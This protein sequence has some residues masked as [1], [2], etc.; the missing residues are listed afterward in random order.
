MGQELA[1]TL[2]F[3]VQS[4]GIEFSQFGIEMKTYAYVISAGRA[5]SKD[6]T[7]EALTKILPIRTDYTVLLVG[8]YQAQNYAAVQDDEGVNQYYIQQK[9]L[10]TTLRTKLMSGFMDIDTKIVL[11]GES[12]TF[13]HFMM[14]ATDA[15]G[16]RISVMRTLL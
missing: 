7:Y 2:G 9:W 6:S 10:T 1:Q 12:T 3:Q 16:N 5:T 13:R 4:Q 11:K 8:Q 14:G 15:T